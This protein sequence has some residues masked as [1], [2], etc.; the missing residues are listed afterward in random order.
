MVSNGKVKFKI[1]TKKQQKQL[2]ADLSKMDATQLQTLINKID[3]D[4][5]KIQAKKI[6]KAKDRKNMRIL[7]DKK[8]L[9]EEHI[10]ENLASSLNAPIDSYT[11]QAQIARDSTRINDIKALQSA[12]EMYYQDYAQ[13]PLDLT[14]NDGGR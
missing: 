8:T 12:I 3:A 5:A 9:I 4:I 6:K 11:L 7:E 14:T 1:L 13:Y 2:K 10:V